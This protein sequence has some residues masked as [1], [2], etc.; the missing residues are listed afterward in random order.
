MKLKLVFVFF[1]T[2]FGLFIEVPFFLK[3][4]QHVGTVTIKR[5]HAN[6][7][8]KNIKHRYTQIRQ[9]QN[10]TTYPSAA[11]KTSETKTLVCK[12]HITL[13]TKWTKF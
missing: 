7:S 10:A 1:L 4:T 3:R 6:I 13:N 12:K 9:K 2:T 11:I 8:K 5:F